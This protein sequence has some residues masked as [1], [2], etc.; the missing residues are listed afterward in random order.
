M[1]ALTVLAALAWLYLVLARHG[2]WRADQV[3]PRA[4]LAPAV[5]P[6]VT[7]IVPARNEAPTIGTC[8]A[9]LAVQDYPGALRIMVVD[10]GS[11]DGTGDIARQA[12]GNRIT[13]VTAPPLT[14]GWTGKLAALQA[15]ID[16]SGDTPLVWF[17]DA[18]IVHGPDVL[19]RLVAFGDA[20]GRD[21]VSLMVKLNCQSFWEKVLIPAFVY[22]FQMLYPFR[23]VNDDQAK[24][25]AAAGGC[26]L[27]RRE[28]L[29]RAGG[30][31]AIRGA[32]IDDCSLGQAV[33]GSGGKLWLGL[34][35]AS[36]SLRS[37]QGLG[38]LWHM[39]ERT[40]FTQLRHSYL[41]LAGTILGLGIL[42]LV[43]LIAAFQ[44]PYNTTVG[45]LGFLAWGLMA[46]SYAPTL[47]MYDLP[48][49]AGFALPLAGLLYA[50]MTVGSA[51]AHLQGRGGAWKGRHYDPSAAQVNLPKSPT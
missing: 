22:F 27:L 30:L 16:V 43:P 7:A 48:I 51:V 33:K 9:A 13:V 12:G 6:A 26:V 28:A 25:A 34:A 36:V 19:R 2:F 21:L 5:W 29:S 40:A 42:F 14:P 8:V 50:G 23:A 11:T 49:L 31:A 24:M 1:A 35:D 38:P 17:T 46:L 18:D 45:V 47:R 4:P 39:V 37:A 3:L 10:D 41:L 20:R 44:F 15:G 32:V